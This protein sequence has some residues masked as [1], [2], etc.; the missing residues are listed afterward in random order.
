MMLD[1]IY[2]GLDVGSHNLKASLVRIRNANSYELL[3][4]EGV[5]TKGFKQ[6]HVSDLG[7]LS[8]SIHRVLKDLSK[9]S[10]VKFKDVYLGLGGN[11][12][13]A[14]YSKA[15]IPLMDKASKVITTSDLKKVNKQARLL[16]IKIDEEILHDFPQQYLVD[17]ANRIL[18][19]AG[20]YGRKLGVTSLLVVS[21]S[22][23]IGNISKAVN[24]AGFEVANV[25]FS[26]LAAAQTALSRDHIQK[27]SLL[28]DIGATTTSI[29]FFKDGFLRHLDVLPIGGQHLTQGVAESLRVPFDLA[30]Q[31]KRSHALV[32]DEELRNNGDILVKKEEGYLTVKRKVIC[33][34]LDVPIAK[35]LDGIQNTLKFSH[36]QEKLSMGVVI[37]GGGAL[38]SGL[39]EKVESA[40]GLPVEIGKIGISLTALNN[41][42]LFT[43]SVGLVQQAGVKPSFEPLAATSPRN[44]VDH[45]SYRVKELYEE[46]F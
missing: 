45:V 25:F 38:L 4:V 39:L 14:R 19:P 5:S 29:L 15:M 28:I 1:K 37:I 41:A 11:A 22:N 42:A 24:Q 23:L 10:N 27:G 17:D 34:A 35:I 20:L 21:Q 9:K 46:Y 30:E 40:T 2:C 7:E 3:G 26:S 12:V 43:S 6:S 31:I 33:S 13:E 44:W 36:I 8:G 18:N 16:G 32:S